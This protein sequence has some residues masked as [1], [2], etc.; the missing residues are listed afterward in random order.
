MNVNSG[1]F[2]SHRL[3]SS[4]LS[5]IEVI[6]PYPLSNLL[7]GRPCTHTLTLSQR[8]KRK[9]RGG[10]GPSF[11]G[12]RR[13]NSMRCL[14]SAA[15]AAATTLTRPGHQH[16]Q[17]TGILSVSCALSWFLAMLC[18]PIYHLADCKTAATRVRVG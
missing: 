13:I 1:A 15:A 6:D 2:T 10:R 7:H 16:G 18:T 4:I 8:R 3:I 17:C 14:L 9:G 5:L 11:N 12:S